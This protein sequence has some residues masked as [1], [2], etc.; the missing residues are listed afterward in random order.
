MFSQSTNLFA[1]TPDG[2][3]EELQLFR[4]KWKE[5][6]RKDLSDGIKTN[7]LSGEVNQR[8]SR[9]QIGRK[10][11]LSGVFHCFGEE[12]RQLG[13]ELDPLDCSKSSD[14]SLQMP[15]DKSVGLFAKDNNGIVLLDLPEPISR[16]A[17]NRTCNSDC[18]IQQ[19]KIATCTKIRKKSLL[20]QLID[21]INEI[22]SI[23]FFDLSLPKEVGIKI[24]NHLGVKELCACAQ[25]SKSWKILSED[26]L[27]W[28]RVGCKLGYIQE[29]D[30]AALDRANWKAFV[31]ESVLEERELRRNWKE[32]MCR[33]SSLEFE[34][35]ET[36]VSTIFY[37]TSH[38]V[39]LSSVL[40]L[41]LIDMICLDF[42]VLRKQ[43]V[44]VGTVVDG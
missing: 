5:E 44:M 19:S 28:Y 21:D 1:M 11:N 30:C 42:Y 3:N 8:G 10:R 36:A 32:R 6:L 23:P 37:V 27:I 35:G 13:D 31:S 4:Q 25:V 33:L 16:D 9:W 24:F 34:R 20:D 41:P 40:R 12:M 38:M 7:C 2:E 15:E 18:K 43:G 26:E 17:C 22:T 14:K 39:L 29:R